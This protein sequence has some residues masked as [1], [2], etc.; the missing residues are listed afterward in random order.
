MVTRVWDFGLVPP[1]GLSS[2]PNCVGGYRAP[3]MIDPCMSVVGD[4]W[5]SEV[6]GLELLRYYSV[7]EEMVQL[8]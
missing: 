7:E 8:L 3:K 2:T 6:F 1:C 4:D 5:R